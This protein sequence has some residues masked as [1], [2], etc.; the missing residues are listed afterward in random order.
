M[1]EPCTE[2]TQV[3][4][5]ERPIKEVETW[6]SEFHSPRQLE[7]DSNGQF[8]LKDKGY[9]FAVVDTTDPCGLPIP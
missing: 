9:S 7:A 8:G 6:E 5:S 4:P 2:R 3:P 1:A